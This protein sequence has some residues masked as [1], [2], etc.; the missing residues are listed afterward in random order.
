MYVCLCVCQLGANM[1][2]SSFHLSQV[3]WVRR[4]GDDIHLITVGRHTYSSD[5][6]YSLQYQAPN[7]WQL[8]IQYANERD[9]GLYECQISSHP[10]LVFLVYLIVVGKLK[11]QQ[12][13]FLSQGN[14]I[15][16]SLLRKHAQI[17]GSI[18]SFGLLIM[19]IFIPLF[20][21]VK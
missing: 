10:P 7:D 9:E 6:R 1:R 12:Q 2:A 8:L 3:T 16:I 19:E 13:S 4:K 11:Q 5:S 17:M 21:G 18:M 15:P 20:P 14:R